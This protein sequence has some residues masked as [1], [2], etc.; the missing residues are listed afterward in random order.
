[1]FVLPGAV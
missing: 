1:M